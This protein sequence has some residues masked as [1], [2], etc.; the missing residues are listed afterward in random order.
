[1][2]QNKIPQQLFLQEKQININQCA[3]IYTN[4]V[5]KI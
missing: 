1:M 5:L 3:L 2:S 4:E